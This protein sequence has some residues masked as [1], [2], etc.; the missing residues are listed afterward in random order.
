MLTKWK[1]VLVLFTILFISAC[2][3][4]S[5]P[6]KADEPEEKVEEESSS[7]DE[8][9]PEIVETDRG[10]FEMVSTAEDIGTYETG[11]VTLD[12]AAASLVTGTYTDDLFIDLIGR[13]DVEY[14]NLGMDLAVSNKDIIFT[15]DH[16]RV[17]T[18]TG[19]MVDPDE[20]MSDGLVERIFR[21]EGVSR[22]FTFFF[23]ETN[24]KDIEELTL[25]VKAPTDQTGNP[26]GDDL[27]IDLPLH[28]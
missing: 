6:E 10:N 3:S 7:N 5:T 11:P 13:E 28:P 26:L 25:Y 27:E 19:E 21:E 4:E 20:K 1:A 15:W 8:K 12:F 14:L 23:D 17:E 22:L 9:E 16:F 24:V 2:S 18:G